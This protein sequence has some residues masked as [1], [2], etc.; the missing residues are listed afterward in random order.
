VRALFTAALFLGSAL[1]FLVQPMFAKM[2]LP[3]V[4]GASTVWTTCLVF[5]QTALL[6]GYA[7]AHVIPARLGE[8]R[9]ARLHLAVLALPFLVLPIAVRHGVSA[10]GGANPTPGL[11][12]SLALSVGAPFLVLAAGGPLLQR[13]F[14]ETAP[15]E[16]PYPLFAASNVGSLAGLLG[17]PLVIEPL[18]GLATQA[19]LF[20][21]GYGAYA[22]LAAVGALARARRNDPVR[23]AASDADAA[24]DANAP[25]P[26]LAEQARWIALAFVPS[27]L[28]LGATT[29]LGADVAAVPLL[30]VPPL[31]LYLVSFIVVFARPP[32][33]SRP[34]QNGQVARPARGEPPA[35][36]WLRV[37]FLA[38][39]IGLF[40]FALPRITQHFAVAALHLALVLLGG[41]LFHGELARRRPAPRSL[42]SFYLA[43]ATGGALGGVFG[44]LVAPL[45]FRGV[46]EYPLAI[47]LALVLMPRPAP[48]SSA[49]DREAAFL[50]SLAEAEGGSKQAALLT[51]EAAA[52]KPARVAALD[53]IVPALAFALTLWLGRRYL[54]APMAFGVPLLACVFLSVRR[55]ARLGLGMIGIALA[56]AVLPGTPHRE[57]SFFGVLRVDERGETRTLLHGTTIH[58]IQRFDAPREPQ[59]YYARGAPIGQLFEALAPRLA[60]A[61]VAAIGLGVGALAAYAERGQRWTFYEIDAAVDRIACRWFTFLGDARARV[62]IDVV[63]GDARL[64]IARAGAG[65]FQLIV[66]DAFSSDA[67]PTHLLTRE[68]FARYREK[69]A[70]GGV[71]TVHIS[72]R[73]LH[74][75]G[76]LAAV[77]RDAGL[78]ARIERGRRDD[79]TNPARATWVVLARSEADF[80]PIAQDPRWESLRDTKGPLWTDDYSDLLGVIRG[81]E[82]RAP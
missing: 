40:F 12:V 20:A 30:W 36:A 44:S 73:H 14:A 19:R 2:L 41:L 17:Y 25:S 79:A 24:R 10:T 82:P 53:V 58:G 42:T 80:G 35:R 48:T 28:L 67:I 39:A 71:I 59:L 50:R 56:A 13:W 72:N 62:P 23:H 69:L 43:I 61:R 26:S 63:L 49:A 21:W 64:T 47:A 32:Q 29:Y 22:A 70:P 75:D 6:L 60:G 74:L 38:L 7:Y 5:F 81:L 68:A 54:G 57:R 4:G 37:S 46:Q 33:P 15:G 77:A 76:V 11:L 8:R 52:T 65:E 18:F 55:Q 51:T 66:L 34:S 9:Q 3:H 45:L 1:L 27:S 78:E 31:A 16:D